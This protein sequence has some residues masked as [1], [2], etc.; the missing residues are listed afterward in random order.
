ML[1]VFSLQEAMHSPNT[2]L[3]M[4]HTVPDLTLCLGVLKHRAPLAKRAHLPA[5]K[6]PPFTMDFCSCGAI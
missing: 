3:S 2:E 6:T 4:V 5:K 1:R